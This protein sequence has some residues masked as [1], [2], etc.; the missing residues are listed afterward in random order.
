M[1][2]DNYVM[3]AYLI[4]WAGVFGY[5]LYLGTR[6]SALARQIKQLAKYAATTEAE[7]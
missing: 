7:R 4:M 3:A 2:T 1:T 5:M 6:C